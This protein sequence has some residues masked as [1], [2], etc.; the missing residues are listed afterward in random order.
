MLMNHL[1]RISIFGEFRLTS[2]KDEGSV[3]KIKFIRTLGF[4]YPDDYFFL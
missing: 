2:G 4:G 1:D 3:R